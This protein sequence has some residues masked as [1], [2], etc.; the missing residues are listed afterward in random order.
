MAYPE[1]QPPDPYVEPVVE[2]TEVVD[3]G[4]TRIR[5]VRAICTLISAVCAIFAVVL[6]I[7]IFLVLASANPDNGFAQLI[8]GWSGAITLGLSDLF[9]TGDHKIQVLLNQGL[10]AILWLVIG[11]ALTAIIGRLALPGPARRIRYRRTVR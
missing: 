10:A 6:V 5:I 8:A 2:S 4:Y 3:D 7:H 1:R 9:T 11:A